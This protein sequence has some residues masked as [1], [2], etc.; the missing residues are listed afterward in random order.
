MLRARLVMVLG[1]LLAASP[2]TFG[3]TTGFQVGDRVVP[4]SQTIGAGRL[5][6]GATRFYVYR[7]AA[8]GKSA[9]TVVIVS[10]TDGQHGEFATSSLIRLS[11]KESLDDHYNL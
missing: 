10:E 7:V 3:Q 4:N 8:T 11:I 6:F 2:M 5:P 1:Y 9:Q